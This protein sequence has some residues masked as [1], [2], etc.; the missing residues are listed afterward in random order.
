M[1]MMSILKRLFRAAGEAY[2]DEK[3]PASGRRRPASSGRKPAAKKPASASGK[4][5]SQQ[6][7]RK[8]GSASR[9]AKVYGEQAIPAGQSGMFTPVPQM[10][11]QM[12]TLSGYNNISGTRSL[13]SLFYQQG[14]FME[15]YTDDYHEPVHC[16]RAVPMYYNMKDNELRAYFTWRTLY[17]Q[18]ALPESQN[19]FL[20]LYSYEALN[21]IGFAS[22][23][24]AYEALG[25][26]LRDYGGQ[27]PSV[28]KAL[29]RWMPDF[30]AYYYL[31]YRL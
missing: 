21:L 12:R 31:P 17:R 23:A 22:A 24:L 11:R 30:A 10:L 26:L 2:L 15:Q 28:R 14:K 29:L 18:G 13:E 7:R 6:A 3:L 19:A 9:S 1:S 25:N 5:A 4:P 27:F 8:T 20:L 16:G